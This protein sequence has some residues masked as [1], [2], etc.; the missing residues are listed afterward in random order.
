MQCYWA[1][2]S[3]DGNVTWADAELTANGEQQ[4]HRIA[5]VHSYL[6]EDTITTILSSPLRR[7]LRT[8]Q[9]A[10]PPGADDERPIIKEKL[11]EPLGV[12]TCDQRSS[13]SWM[14]EDYPSFD[15]E[16]GSTEEGLLWSPDRQEMIEEHTVRCT[17]LLDDIFEGD[18]GEYIVLA[19]HSG[20]VMSLF[21]ATGLE[22]DTRR[23]QSNV[24]SVGLR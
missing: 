18:Y 16:S 11:R 5:E 23:G 4:A 2:V 12:R 3:G 24:S 8:V 15:V 14:V 19:A 17:E 9:L 1:K 6:G 10:F 22:E 20:A 7:C 21:A 13:R